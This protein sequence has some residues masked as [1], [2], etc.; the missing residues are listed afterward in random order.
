M[1]NAT[2]EVKAVADHLTSSCDE[3][4]VGRYLAPVFAAIAGQAA[5]GP[6]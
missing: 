4:G 6:R 3:S 2:P 1:G 5:S